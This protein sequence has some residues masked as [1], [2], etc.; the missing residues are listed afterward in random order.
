MGRPRSIS[1]SVGRVAAE[2]MKRLERAME[3]DE[4]LIPTEAQAKV[5]VLL[6][7]AQAILRTNKPMPGEEDDER[8]EEQVKAGIESLEAE[9]QHLKG[10]RA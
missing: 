8:P 2:T 9:T 4:K 6:S 7:K 1:T 5:I 10:G 3:L